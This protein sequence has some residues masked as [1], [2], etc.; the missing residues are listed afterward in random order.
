[1][2]DQDYHIVEGSPVHGDDPGIGSLGRILSLVRRLSD[3]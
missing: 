3:K 2:N 1:M